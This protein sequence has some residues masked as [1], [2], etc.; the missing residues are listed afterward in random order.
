MA[1]IAVQVALRQA[2]EMAAVSYATQMLA[3][4]TAPATGKLDNTFVT[5]S[6]YNTPMPIVF[7]QYRCDAQVIWALQLHRHTKSGHYQAT[8]ASLYAYMPQAVAGAS[9]GPL[10]RRIFFNGTLHWDSSVLYST[11]FAGWI[12]ISNVADPPHST[13][14]GNQ[15]VADS[16]MVTRSPGGASTVAYLGYSGSVFNALNAFVYG[17]QI[18]PMHSAVV[19]GGFLT[20]GGFLRLCLNMQS[21]DPSIYGDF[22]DVDGILINQSFTRVTVGASSSSQEV[23]STF[24][25]QVGDNVAFG[26]TGVTTTIASVVDSTHI[27]L[28]ASVVT[29]TGMPVYNGGTSS[30]FPTF[31]GVCFQGSGS[32]GDLMETVSDF[33][34]VDIFE[35]EGKIKARRRLADTPDFTILWDDL[36]MMEYDGSKDPDVRIVETIAYPMDLPGLVRVTYINSNDNFLTGMVTA[37]R[38]GALGTNTTDKDWSMI[39]CSADQALNAAQGWLDEQYIQQRSFEFTLGPTYYGIEVGDILDVP[40]DSASVRVERV[41]VKEIQ[42][43][44]PAGTFKVICVR[45]SSASFSQSSSG[46]SGSGT[47]GGTGATNVLVTPSAVVWSAPEAYPADP[48]ASR[49]NFSVVATW[50]S[51][52][53]RQGLDIWYTLAGSSTKIFAGNIVNQTPIGHTTSVMPDGLV[54]GDFETRSTT[55][56]MDQVGD[57]LTTVSEDEAKA[58]SNYSLVGSELL[59]I[60]V[61]TKTSDSHFTASDMTGGLNGSPLTGHVSPEPFA[62]L[63]LGEVLRVNFAPEIEQSL[64]GT[65]VTVYVVATGDDIANAAVYTVVIAAPAANA[66][67]PDVIEITAPAWWHDQRF[68]VFQPRYNS[69]NPVVTGYTFQFQYSLDGGSTWKGPDGTSATYFYDKSFFLLSWGPGTTAKV[70][71]RAIT[72]NGSI[73]NWVLT[74]NLDY[75]PPNLQQLK[76]PCDVA[77]TLAMP[78]YTYLAPFLTAN[79]NGALPTIDGFNSWVVAGTAGMLP[80]RILLTQEGPYNG[81]W[82]VVQ[83]GSVSL[84]WK[85]SRSVDMQQSGDLVVGAQIWVQNGVGGGWWALS[86]PVTT[87]VINTSSLVFTQQS[88]STG[89]LQGDNVST[90]LDGPFIELYKPGAKQP[91]DYVSISALPAYTH[92]SGTITASSNGAFPAQDGETPT[93]GDCYLMTSEATDT[94]NC[95]M[96]LDQVGSVSTPF[97]LHRRGDFDEPSEI[98]SGCMVSAGFGSSRAGYV[99]RMKCADRTVVLGTTGFEWEQVYPGPAVPSFADNETPSG[100]VNGSNVTFTLAHAPSPAGSLRLFLNG[101]RLTVTTDYSLSTL[102]VTMG[103]APVSGDVLLADYRY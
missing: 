51:G 54:V 23:D 87:L 97:I 22:S 11:H 4:A 39:A 68:Q 49:P 98:K 45:C 2:L 47:G 6:Q 43:R 85:L 66:I 79:A 70:R 8:F 72:P 88:R 12:P 56:L 96:I 10:V 90:W 50:P 38:E 63:S 100:L 34:Q 18:P 71:A 9:E 7:G 33:Y 94:F 69:Q 57:D 89:V 99:Y 82:D 3:T 41:R 14:G 30:H 80:T 95:P 40:L 74:S 101:Q 78:A 91:V 21:L 102:T 15:N 65:V 29:T 84:P 92:A 27:T 17:N 81:L 76:F 35:S 31:G 48:L 46:T 73:G 53:N 28:A 75:D 37:S 20:L 24:G 83:V 77:Q 26:S 25:M 93:V 52:D 19:D 5:G 36:G 1:T 67:D 44:N 62:C 86:G 42:D 58:G 103:A 16:F 32:W 60:A 55:L 61:F 64:I 13:F 59:E